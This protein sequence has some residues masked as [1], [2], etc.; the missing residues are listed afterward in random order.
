MKP[1]KDSLKDFLLQD[2]ARPSGP[3]EQAFEGEIQ[4]AGEAQ[5]RK[6]PRLRTSDNGGAENVY[7]A[8][9]Y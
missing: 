7:F 6:K 1:C 3:K 8:L 5:A 4:A 2:G 9:F